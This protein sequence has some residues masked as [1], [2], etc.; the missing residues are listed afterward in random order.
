MAARNAS[1]LELPLNKRLKVFHTASDPDATSMPV[2][3]SSGCID[4]FLDISPQSV[5]RVIAQR[6]TLRATT[7]RLNV[8]QWPSGR[9]SSPLMRQPCAP[10]PCAP[11]V[12][13]DGCIEQHVN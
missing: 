2:V 1:R 9:I 11:Y 10:V 13:Y 5:E 12:I 4:K 8:Q 3:V 6:D 7:Q